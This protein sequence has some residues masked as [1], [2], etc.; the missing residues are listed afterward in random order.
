MKISKG[1]LRKYIREAIA[2]M[3]DET[4]EFYRDAQGNRRMVPGAG[5]TSLRDEEDKALATYVSEYIAFAP[6]SDDIEWAIRQ[7]AK[8]EGVTENDVR[9]AIKKH[10]IDIDQFEEA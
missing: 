9:R 1:Q 5:W 10:G 7:V 2:D 3:R 4:T 6:P 8:D